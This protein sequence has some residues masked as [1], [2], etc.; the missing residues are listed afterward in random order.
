MFPI[1]NK[2]NM[3]QSISGIYD[4]PK[5]L[6]V[7][8]E[9]K[10]SQKIV[11]KH[12]WNVCVRS[13]AF[14]GCAWGCHKVST[15]RTGPKPKLNPDLKTHSHLASALTTCDQTPSD[16]LEGTSKTVGTEAL[17]NGSPTLITLRQI[18]TTYEWYDGDVVEFFLYLSVQWEWNKDWFRAEKRQRHFSSECRA[19]WVRVS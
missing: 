17:I 11:L 5:T 18:I 19:V 12:L 13:D 14:P 7:Q 10:M 8:N 1:T 15:R 9:I 4:I 2:E 3:L 16:W 6:S